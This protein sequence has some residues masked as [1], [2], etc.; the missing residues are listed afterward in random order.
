MGREAP[1]DSACRFAREPTSKCRI[2][3]SGEPLM[4]QPPDPTPEEMARQARQHLDSLRRAGVE[5]LPTAPPPA[6]K[7]AA[8]PA[9]T[10]PSL[11]AAEDALPAA[12]PDLSV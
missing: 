11:F 7:G 1:A 8:A 10:G 3:L 4:S 2:I 9:P 12:T 6:R 5:W